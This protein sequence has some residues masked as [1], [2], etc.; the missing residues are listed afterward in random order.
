MPTRYHVG[1]VTPATADAA[2][3]VAA[4]TTLFA[5]ATDVDTGAAV[6]GM[7]WTFGA[8]WAYSGVF[9]P[10][11][12]RIIIAVQ[13]AGSPPSGPTMVAS[14]DTYTAANVLIGLCD[15]A[16][17][18]YVNWYDAAPF[19]GCTFA[20]YYRLCAV[21]GLT[22]GSIRAWVSTKDLLL[23]TATTV[24]AACHFGATVTGKTGY[25]ETDGYRYG[26]M[27]SGIGDMS[28]AWRSNT[29]TTAGFFGKNGTANGNAHAGLYA[30]GGSTWQTIRVAFVR[31]AGG[32]ADMGKWGAGVGA[33][34]GIK[35]QRSA[36]PEYTV[37]SWSGMSEG[38][39]ALTAALVNTGASMLW[40]WSLSSAVSGAAEES[41]VIGQSY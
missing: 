22:T 5:V 29:L 17:G 40:G 39:N 12:T 31:V 18:A 21:S 20:G 10:R 37:G 14:A 11:N 41:V 26:G 2:G 3:V 38:A 6:S 16:A 9:G 32:T 27:V 7:S 28:S 15:N 33:R 13:D 8:S 34:T 1:T 24:V 30:V 36:S 19:S 23:Q 25:Q 35:L 4:L